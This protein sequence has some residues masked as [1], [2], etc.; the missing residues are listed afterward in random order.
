MDV[1]SERATDPAWAGVRTILIPPGIVAVPRRSPPRVRKRTPW[2]PTPDGQVSTPRPG[3]R[4]WFSDRLFVKAQDGHARTGY[5]TSIGAHA[6]VG[7][8]V[9]GF[10]ITRAYQPILA[11]AG[12]LAMPAFVSSLPVAPTPA[13][14]AIDRAAVKAVKVVPPE[15]AAPPPLEDVN[16]AAPIVAP[17][18]IAP[19]TGNE[20]PVARVDGSVTGGIAGGVAGGVGSMPAASGSAPLRVGTGIRPPRKTK[21]VKPVYPVDALPTR[22]QGAVLIEAIIGVD[23]KVQDAKV[24]HSIPSLDQAALD[25]VRQ[26]EYEPSLLNGVPVAVVMTIVVNFALQ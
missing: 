2:H 6:C 8:A 9:L 24:L 25:A 23:G 17:S 10:L 12:P 20:T 19:E 14:H 21:N 26:W 5:G 4:E 3:Q 16:A 11:R 15:E 13:S 22:A 7:L 1:C 18:G